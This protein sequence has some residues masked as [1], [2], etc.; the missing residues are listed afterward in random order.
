MKIGLVSK[1]SLFV[2]NLV[3][4]DEQSNRSG[5]HK[6]TGLGTS[7]KT[8]S[9]AATTKPPAV[10]FLIPDIEAHFSPAKWLKREFHKVQERKKME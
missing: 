9:A 2:G 7:F 4:G 10:G 5:G 3:M 1:A 8:T 6:W